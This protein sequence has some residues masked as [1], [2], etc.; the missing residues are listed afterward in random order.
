MGSQMS[1]VLSSLKKSQKITEILV[2][3][4]DRKVNIIKTIED[5]ITQGDGSVDKIAEEL[6]A[7]K[8]L[9]VYKFL[10]KEESDTFDSILFPNDALWSF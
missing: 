9:D 7:V 3:A 1:L 8:R 5:L 4:A 10:T 6:R 2:K